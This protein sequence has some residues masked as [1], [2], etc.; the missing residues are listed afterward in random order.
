MKTVLVIILIAVVAGCVSAPESRSKEPASEVFQRWEKSRS[1]Y[2]L[3]ELVDA[4]ID[5]LSN[6]ASKSDV[7]KYLGPGIDTPDHHPNAG[8]NMWVYP[9]IRRVPHGSYLIIEFDDQGMV[10]RIGWVSE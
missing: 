1:Y 2:A 5:P 7:E 4:Y 9:S 8:P 3:L 6:K 10:Q